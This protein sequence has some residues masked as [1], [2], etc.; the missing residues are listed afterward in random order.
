MCRTIQI[1][2]FRAKILVSD[3][4]QVLLC[5]MQRYYEI[6]SCPMGAMFNERK[7]NGPLNHKIKGNIM[8]YMI[9]SRFSDFPF[10]LCRKRAFKCVKK[11]LFWSRAEI[12]P[13]GYHAQLDSCAE[14]FLGVVQK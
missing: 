11:E 3:S 10:E 2:G 13:S 1:R 8:Y 9:L 12:L 4:R 14:P 6:M 5:V 7:S